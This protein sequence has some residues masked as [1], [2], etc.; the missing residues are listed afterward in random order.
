MVAKSRFATVTIV[1]AALSLLHLCYGMPV[2]DH[3]TSAVLKGIPIFFL[4]ACTC[5]WGR[6]HP[7]TIVALIFSF[8]GDS[9]GAMRLPGDWSFRLMVIFFGIAQIHYISEFL[10]YSPARKIPA[11]RACNLTPILCCLYAVVLLGNLI[12]SGLQKRDH[13]KVFLTGS[14]LFVISDSMIILRRL[15]PGFKY[16]GLAIM[17]T[18]YLAQYLLNIIVISE[19]HSAG[20]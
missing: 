18:Y 16:W 8:L 5:I 14:I 3:M 1:F 15:A 11:D 20:K 9:A 6:K 4:L 10:R 12:T 19:G 17:V 13:K 2:A 7:R